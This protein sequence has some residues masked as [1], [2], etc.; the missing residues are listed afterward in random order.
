MNR[1]NNIL[2]CADFSLPSELALTRAALLARAKSAR[3]T[4]VHVLKR[5]ALDRLHD[6]LAPDSDELLRQGL[7]DQAR[8]EIDALCRRLASTYDIEVTDQVVVGAVIR[9]IIDAAA[10]CDAGLI[11]LG[12]RGAGFISEL[13]LGSTTERVLSRSKQPILVVKQQAGER[14]RRVLIAVDFSA[15]SSTTIELAR[16][17]APDA[18]MVLL[19]VFDV[20]FEGK[21]RYAGVAEDKVRHLRIAAKQAALERMDALIADMGLSDAKVRRVLHHGTAGTS[22]VAQARELE[23]DLVAVGRQGKGLVEEVLIGSVAKHVLGFADTD[24]LVAL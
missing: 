2:A 8:S 17:L 6:L 10:A 9:E 24:V 20:P 22:I 21:L 15:Q 11:V 13:I 5:G 23:C 12:D 14:Y 7:M 16:E 19:H 18:E 3:L 1:F 4:L